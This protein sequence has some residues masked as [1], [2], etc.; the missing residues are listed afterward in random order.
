ME[1]KLNET[2]QALVDEEE[3][4]KSLAKQKTKQDAVIADLEERL[5]NEERV[6]EI[7]SLKDIYMQN[8]SIFFCEK[9]LVM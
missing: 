9:K 5:K 3:K 8:T 6:R 7:L 4:A 1:E 2:S